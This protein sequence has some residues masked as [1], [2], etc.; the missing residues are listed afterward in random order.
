MQ[1]GTIET[2]DAMFY[3]NGGPDGNYSNRKN[4]TMT[5]MPWPTEANMIKVSFSEFALEADYDFLYIYDGTSTNAT[6][7]GS[8]TGGTSPGEV[9]ATNSQGAL[10]FQFSSDQAVNASGW[11][12]PCHLLRPALP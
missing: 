8:Y 3:D 5:F 9:T 11:K 7:I 6:L 12:A 10:T 1:N 2:C 4:Y